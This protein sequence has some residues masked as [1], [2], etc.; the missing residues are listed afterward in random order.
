MICKSKNTQ[1][2]VK[3][4]R[5]IATAS[6]VCGKRGTHYQ[7]KNNNIKKK[8]SRFPTKQQ[9]VIKWEANIRNNFLIT[10]ICSKPRF[11]YM[12]KKW[13]FG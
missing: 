5:E 2:D 3:E 11:T 9:Y 13:L 10:L 7:K 4:H 6:L 12:L 1:A 8:S